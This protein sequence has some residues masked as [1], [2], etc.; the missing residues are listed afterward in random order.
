MAIHQILPNFDYGDAIG[1]NVRA[2]RRLLGEW[3]DASEVFAQYVHE[4]LKGEA[5]YYTHYRAVSDPRNVLL[6]HFSIGSEVTSFFAGLPDRKILIYHNITPAEF[7]TGINAR[8]ASHCRRGRL[9]LRR[10]AN[11]VDMALGDSEFNRQELEALGF[12]RT[13]VLPILLDWADYAHPPVAALEGMYRGRTVL[14]SAGR[15]APNKRIEELIKTYYFYRRLDP[16]ALLVVIGGAVDMEGYLAGC[17]ALAAELGVADGVVF[18]GRV[19]QAELCT[20]YRLAACY[21]CLSE[22]EGFCVPLLEAMHFDVPIVAYASTGVPG[23]LGD[24]GLL[25]PEKDFPAIAELIHHL[26]TT[27][28]LLKE[29]LAGQ[30]E[31]L[32]AFEPSAIGQR[33]KGYLAELELR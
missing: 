3:G 24:A 6:F 30:R 33:L 5:R 31:R 23:T 29:V 28:A 19:S 16:T 10:L 13:G 1:N 9:E 21:L 15:I 2:L 25:L 20:Y 12:R 22:H 18:T 27:P 8:V 14:L 7:F 26:L 17:Q 32:R 4:R 11:A